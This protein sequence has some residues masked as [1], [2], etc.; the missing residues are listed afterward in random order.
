MQNTGV[1][2]FMGMEITFKYDFREKLSVG[3][4]YSYIERHNNTNP[5]VL[6]TDIPNTKVFL[7]TQYKPIKPI[8][9]LA[10]TEFN[11]S[12]N[13]S[14]YGTKAADFTLVNSTVS[15]R[16]WRYTDIE[17]G[18]NNVFDKNYRLVEGYPEEGRNFFV[19][20]RIFN[21]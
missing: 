19:T 1:A 17:A 15:A 12:R 14:S 6:F 8:R 20:L 9:L 10:S 13:S 18:I 21:N 16:L 4:N 2:E 5:A 7:Y 11:T 3:G